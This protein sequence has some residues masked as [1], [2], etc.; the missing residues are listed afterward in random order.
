MPH[1]DMK[2]LSEKVKNHLIMGLFVNFAW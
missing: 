2:K 1:A